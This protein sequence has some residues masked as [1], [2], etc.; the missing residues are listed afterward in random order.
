MLHT[1]NVVTSCILAS[2]FNFQA[3]DINWDFS[4]NIGII[5]LK[6]SF[7]FA[8]TENTAYAISKEKGQNG[9]KD[10]WTGKM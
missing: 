3:F 9:S 1:G 2:K 7:P 5:P 8:I 4:E 6:T 10:F